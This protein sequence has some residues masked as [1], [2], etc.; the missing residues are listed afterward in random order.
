MEQNSNKLRKLVEQYFELPDEDREDFVQSI[1]NDE[2]EVNIL[3]L[4]NDSFQKSHLPGYV[5][6]DEIEEFLRKK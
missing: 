3:S 6:L 5:D 1:V 4:F 2:T